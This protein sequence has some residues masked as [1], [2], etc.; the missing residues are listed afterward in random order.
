[1][2][3]TIADL[4]FLTYQGRPA[5]L[6]APLFTSRQIEGEVRRANAERRDGRTDWTAIDLEEVILAYLANAAAVASVRVRQR[7]RATSSR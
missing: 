2:P 3:I 5:D 6:R 4:W 7:E 1:V